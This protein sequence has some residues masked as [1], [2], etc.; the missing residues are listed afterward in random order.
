MKRFASSRWNLDPRSWLLNPEVQSGSRMS[1]R[2]KRLS[3]SSASSPARKL[4]RAS[5]PQEL[6][7]TSRGSE[8]GGGASPTE[9]MCITIDG[10]GRRKSDFIRLSVMGSDGSEVGLPGPL[11][12][13]PDFRNGSATNP[14]GEWSPNEHMCSIAGPDDWAWFGFMR[15]FLS[16][17]VSETSKM[18]SDRACACGM[19]WG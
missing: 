19:G 7:E 15:S 1:L 8:E 3:L 2:S 17:L 9:R 13:H 18:A 14:R 6:P 5:A 10:Q 4:R 16:I 11:P 12:S